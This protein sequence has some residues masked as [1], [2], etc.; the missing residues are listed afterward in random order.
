MREDSIFDQLLVGA[1]KQRIEDKTY[2]IEYIDLKRGPDD[3]IIAERSKKY[4]ITEFP[5][6][7][8]RIDKS[9]VL[10]VFERP[11]ENAQWATYIGSIDPVAE[12]KT[13]TSESLCSIYIYKNAVEVTKVHES[14][15]VE[16]YVESEGIVAAWCG[17]YDDIN[18]THEQLEL[19]IEWY[20]AWTLVENNVSLFINYMIERRKQKYLVPKNQIVF[21]KEAGANRQVY[22]DY[23]WKNT[24][25]LFKNHLLSYLIEWLNEV[26]DH[27]TDEDGQPINKKYGI[28]RL[29]DIM[30]LIE[31][32]NYKEGVNVDRLVSLAALISFVKVQQANRGYAKRVDKPKKDLEKSDNLYKLNSSPFRHVGGRSRRSGSK[33]TR[34]PFRKI[35]R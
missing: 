2:P 28:E 32:Q 5:V 26:I 3:K 8:K 9:G 22:S 10:V 35:G 30:A 25:T 13:T 19:I 33:G 7:K 20:K 27:D 24:G 34:S 6:D 23:G 17:R 16:N 14:G 18:K 1:Q 11:D 31:M 15:A 4:P 21:L 29:P 12:G